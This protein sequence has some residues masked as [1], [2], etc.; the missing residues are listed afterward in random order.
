MKIRKKQ[1]WLLPF[2]LLSLLLS[3]CS[4]KST[5]LD[6]SS[7]TDHRLKIVTTIYP[8]YDF[9]KNIVGENADVTMLLP[10]GT[11]SHSYEPSPK[12]LVAIQDSDLFIYA[13]GVGDYWVDRV[14]SSMG[15]KAPR[16]FVLMDAVALLKE[17]HKEGMA[18]DKEEDEEL[19]EHVWT[20]PKNALTITSQLAE[21]I[22]ILDPENKELYQKNKETY[23][24]KLRELDAEL[25][26]IIKNAKR[27]TIVIG[28]RFPFRYLTH[29]YGLDYYAAFPGC[30]TETEPSAAQVAFLSD[31]VGLEQVPIVFYLEFS[32]GKV[33]E[34]IA[35]DSGAK[36]SIL[37]SAHNVSR[38]D[39]EAGIG[40]LDIM[41][42]NILALK[43]AL[44]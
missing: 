30:S 23:E 12:D 25:T 2:I 27:H 32:N 42:K 13:G 38:Q 7:N 8:P 9:A 15:N 19:D 4:N 1:F 41:K 37:H 14:L 43:E 24:E 39:F 36:T 21:E 3:G 29:D 28:D 44:N 34:A 6:E 26:E 5:P 18:E 31:K 16:T 33:A 11:E 35:R 22:S 10:L 40:Y 17:E 20:S